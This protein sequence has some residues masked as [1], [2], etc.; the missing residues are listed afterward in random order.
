MMTPGRSVVVL[1]G[2]LDVRVCAWGEM[3]RAVLCVIGHGV[4]GVG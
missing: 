4:I 1:S 3:D 2:R